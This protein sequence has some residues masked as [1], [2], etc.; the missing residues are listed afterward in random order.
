MYNTRSAAGDIHM[1]TFTRKA[2]MQ[3]FLHILKNKP[4]DRITV[5]DI[6][7]QCEI[8][9]NTF[10]Y[11][12]KDIYDVLETIFEDE[13]RLVMDEA[14]EGV[15]FHDA[16][17]RAAALILNNSEAIRHIYASEN[18]RVLRTYLD[19]VVTQVVRRF[20]LE[21]AEGYSLDDSDIAFITAFYSNGIVGSTIKWIEKGSMMS[22]LP[23]TNI[24]EK[25]F[26]LSDEK[27]GCVNKIEY[28]K[29]IVK[30]IG[31]SFEATIYDMIE[32]CL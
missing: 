23:E 9:R 25:C 19:A 17:A 14:K 16:Y 21:K 20:V 28:N 8:N 11:Y 26:G 3:T 7:E 22:S 1:A 18:G 4:L 31:D 2:I 32:C 24:T 27:S 10:Y 12:F 15:T 5:K 30:R 29:D 13:V 6:C